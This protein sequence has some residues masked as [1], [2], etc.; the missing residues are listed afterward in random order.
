[1]RTVAEND[2]SKQFSS[3]ISDPVPA[4][5][6]SE[7]PLAFKFHGYCVSSNKVRAELQIVPMLTGLFWQIEHSTIY[8][9]APQLKGVVR[10]LEMRQRTSDVLRALRA[11]EN[12]FE[13]L[14]R[15]DPLDKH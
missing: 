13:R 2:L 5:D 9:P 15:R 11:F 8:K 10:S 12:E 6:E 1:M 14:V 4:D 3:W 7:E